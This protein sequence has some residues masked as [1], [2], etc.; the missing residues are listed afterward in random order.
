[1]LKFT[2]KA[3]TLIEILI[4]SVILWIVLTVIFQIYFSLLKT[5]TDIYARSILVKNTNNVV[6][7]LNIIMKNY[8]ID[9]E[10]YFDRRMVWCNS[11]GWN[12]FS[13][14]VGTWWYCKKFTD[15]W[16]G[17]SIKKDSS[18]VNTWDNILYYCSSKWDDSDK[19]I[20]FPGKTTDCEWNQWN[21]ITW[22]AYIYHQSNDNL[23][24]WSGCWENEVSSDG[25]MQSFG[26][27]KLQFWNVGWN[28]DS[29]MWCKWDDDDT[30]LWVWPVAIGDNLHVKELYLISKDGK[31]RIFI[32]RKLVWT[33]D[34]N[35]DW[36]IDYTW[37]EALYKLQI[38]KL[39]WFDIGSWH[40]YWTTW[41][42]VNDGKID[43]WACDKLQW[44]KCNWTDI[45]YPGGWYNLPKDVNDGWVD[46]TINDITIS[47]FNIA[48]FPTKSPNH[49]WYDTGVQISPYLRISIKTNFYPI[50]YVSKI[51]PIMISKYSMN[52]QTTFSIKPY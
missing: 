12:N 47:K 19:Q 20:E 14:D 18:F 48:I 23:N 5:R 21:W 17:S 30:D 26:E 11:D 37:W 9:Y 49:A 51:N 42:T 16:N 7:K 28:A 38:L 33:W 25:A 35:H 13:W 43:T 44:F 15:Y 41:A 27:Y 3:F 36:N 2:K 50:N 40:K 52:L 8:T 29:Y 6:E 45:N 10:E 1:M 34:W 31:H 39:R 46:M 4:A 22:S 24:A 32:R